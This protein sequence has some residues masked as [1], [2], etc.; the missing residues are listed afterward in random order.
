MSGS[1][2]STP[3]VCIVTGA[4]SGIGAEVAYE[5]ADAGWLVAG[6]DLRPAPAC[7][8]S[9]Q[10]DM[11]DPD[12]VTRAVADVTDQLGPVCGA[13]SA[14]GHYESV[15]IDAVSATQ[16]HRMLRVHLGGF[17]N[18]ARAVL[19]GMTVAGRG[20]I[21]AVTSELAQGGG[22]QDSHYS[23]AKGALIGAV[24]SLA[25]EVGPTGVRVNAVAPGPTDTPLLAADSPWREEAYL[26]TL[27][28]RR[29]ATPREVALGV[30]F[31][32]ED[33]TFATG[34]VLDINSGAVI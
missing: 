28:A 3:G 17:V 1:A 25:A 30:V 19:P 12:D 26:R 13:V 24:R 6:F 4:G 14:A 32:L 11:A 15:P 7:R 29:L 2:A 33:A 9:V 10:V 23:A 34:E 27:P 31:L 22:E 21:V 20:G 5:L 18:L 8:M 16:W